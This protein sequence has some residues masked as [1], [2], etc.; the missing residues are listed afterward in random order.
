MQRI[1]EESLTI[2]RILRPPNRIL[3][4]RILRLP[5]RP[6]AVQ[7][8]MMEV[9]TRISRTDERIILQPAHREMA[10]RMQRRRE[11]KDIGVAGFPAVDALE[12][13]GEVRA[14]EKMLL[15]AEGHGAALV[16]LEVPRQV[17]GIVAE[18]LIVGAV[19]SGEG[20]GGEEGGGVRG[21]EGGRVA[22][23]YLGVGFSRG[24]WKGERTGMGAMCGN[25]M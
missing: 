17:A 15:V 8:R 3:P 2:E 7:L 11:T 6:H 10:I 9:E 21:G 18:V 20:V 1:R 19:G 24:R 25:L 5:N 12:E 16:V 22:E 23:V 14:A 13:A 4:R